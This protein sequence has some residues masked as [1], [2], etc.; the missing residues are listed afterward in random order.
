MKTTLLAGLFALTLAATAQAQGLSAAQKD[1]VRKLIEETIKEKPEVIIQSLTAL[2]ER[3]QARMLAEQGKNLK[4]VLPKLLSSDGLTVL[5]NPKGD[6]TVVEFFDYNCGYC[7]RIVP[8][9]QE[10]LKTDKNVRW[11]LVDLPILS[12]GSKYAA[13][14][15]LASEKQGKF[16]DFHLAM[17][18]FKGQLDEAKVLE[19]AKGAKLD[20]EK[21]KTDIASPALEKQLFENSNAAR[22]IGVNGTPAFVVGEQFAPGAVGLEALQELIAKARKAGKKD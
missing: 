4:D 13:K 3:E 6:V 21:L 12:E 20:V 10:I 22:A 16:F 15:A 18:N 9:L 5:G 19:L 2:R 8:I 17:L 1:E 11:V 7:K 14:A